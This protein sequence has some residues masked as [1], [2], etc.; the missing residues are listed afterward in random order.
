[1]TN[2][3]G[4]SRVGFGVSGPLGQ[5]WFSEARTRALI[6]QALAG[7]VTH[8]DTGPFYFD[9]ERQLGDALNNAGRKDVFVSTKTGTRRDGRRLIKDFSER[10]VRNDVD[11]S[12]RRLRKEALDLLYLHGPTVKQIDETLP[13]LEAL[14]REGLIGKL[15]VCGEGDALAHA[16]ACGVDAIMGVYNVID[17]R[18]EAVFAE[19]RRDGVMTVAIAPLMQG[20]VDPNFHRPSS[21]TDIWRLARAAFRG[22]YKRRDIEALRR[23][24]AGADPVEAALGFALA[25]SD[26]DIVMTTSTRQSHLAQSLAIAGKPI[27][28]ALHQALKA[29][30]LDPG[31]G[32]T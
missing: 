25:N 27:G 7:G 24:I 9:A 5:N 32:R 18:H 21:A 12:R 26:I 14:K 20:L 6:E 1:M 19:A 28:P 2:L 23:A 30:S 17:R 31:Q 8:F 22:R 16:V 11:E 10:A 13:V 15:G 29:L 3:D 4:A